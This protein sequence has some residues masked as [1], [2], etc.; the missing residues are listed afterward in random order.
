MKTRIKFWC[1]FVA[2][3][4]SAAFAVSCNR[5]QKAYQNELKKIVEKENGTCPIPCPPF[6]TL[7]S[8]DYDQEENEVSF[9]FSVNDAQLDFS[10]D[11]KEHEPLMKESFELIFAHSQ[12]NDFM[13]HVKKAEASVAVVLKS[14]ISGKRLT[15]HYS[16]KEVADIY[17][18]ALTEEEIKKKQLDINLKIAQTLLSADLGDGII[19][20][21]VSLD[22]DFIVYTTDVPESEEFMVSQIKGQ[23][24]IL[25]AMKMEMTPLFSGN[26]K[27][28]ALIKSLRDVGY[29]MKYVFVGDLS[30]DSF[31]IIWTPE[32]LK[33]I[34][35]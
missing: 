24:D 5:Q 10:F 11:N 20:K 12:L 29:G 25:G 27:S 6:G 7:K 16:P 32:E 30:Y 13:G 35:L 31:E 34:S 19:A 15:L 3:V 2:L 17:S 9:N 22:G 23:Q 8:V 1:M 21:T 33:A 28:R 4:A 26:V 18:Q 14:D